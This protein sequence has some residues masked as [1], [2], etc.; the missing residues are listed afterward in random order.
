MT[1]SGAYYNKEEDFGI[2]NF[3]DLG[4]STAENA[5]NKKTILDLRTGMEGKE[6]LPIDKIF[7]TVLI[8][9]LDPVTLL[10]K[11]SEFVHNEIEIETVKKETLRR[12]YRV[13]IA[14]KRFQRSCIFASCSFPL[15]IQ[16]AGYIIGKQVLSKMGVCQMVK[17][18]TIHCQPE[19]KE[20]LMVFTEPDNFPIEIHCTQGKDRTGMISALVLSIAGVPEEI[21]VNDYAKTQKG[22]APVY[23]Q[24]LEEVR[25]I[26]LSDDF[27]QAPPQYMRELLGFLKEKHGSVDNYLDAI[28]FGKE[29]RERVRKNICV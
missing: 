15:K 27:V 11:D 7:P 12:K 13:D 25:R 24:M 18:F 26:G 1:I 9:Q 14:G 6:G 17:E 28:G 22:L 20:A 3:R 29:L 8:D 4:V 2:L 23:Q 19:I 21:I 5:E 10:K 16:K